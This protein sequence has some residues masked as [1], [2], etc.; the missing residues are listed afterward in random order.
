VE[1]DPTFPKVEARNLE[2][3]GGH[4]ARRVRRRTQRGAAARMPDHRKD[5]KSH[6]RWRD[7]LGEHCLGGSPE[8]V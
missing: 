7:A 8:A 5:A 6:C 2:G 4:T 3:I 1:A